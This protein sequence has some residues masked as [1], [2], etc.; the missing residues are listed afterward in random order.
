MINSTNTKEDV[1]EWIKKQRAN[2]FSID[3]IKEALA[4]RG[5]K[6]EKI[7]KIFSDLTSE[8]GKREQLKKEAVQIEKK[9]KDKRR[10]SFGYKFIENK[11][12]A[13][14]LFLGVLFIILIFFISLESNENEQK[15]LD[16]I[17]KDMSTE[18][19]KKAQEETSKNS[20]ILLEE[21][22]L[23]FDVNECLMYAAGDIS[24]LEKAQEEEV[25]QLFDTSFSR[26]EYSQKRIANYYMFNAIMENNVASCNKI[27]E[28]QSYALNVLCRAIVLNDP[29]IC[30]EATESNIKEFII[31]LGYI[32]FN[33][34]CAAYADKKL[35][36][37]RLIVSDVDKEI[38][39]DCEQEIHLISA[40]TDK[41]IEKC[42]VI[43]DHGLR[44]KCLS[45]ISGNTEHC[46]NYASEMCSDIMNNF[47]ANQY[48]TIIKSEA[49]KICNLIGNSEIKENCIAN[50]G[51]HRNLILI[52]NAF[53]ADSFIEC[54]NIEDDDARISC[55]SI[56]QSDVDM[57]LKSGDY[58]FDCIV[59]LIEFLDQPELCNEL[60]DEEII[61]CQEYVKELVVVQT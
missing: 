25:T 23:Y 24:Y 26:Q 8:A 14:I 9:R 36:S 2:G 53:A 12:I 18:D 55:L 13:A 39:T 15:A 3:N 37:C 29:L 27:D 54:K 34:L 11:K 51:K 46:S 42:N 6:E 44:F 21:C 33:S 49:L 45:L 22:K 19:I 48:I 28:P 38:I 1:K 4:K 57:C 20:K 59:N 47:I 16:Q 56:L 50:V 52:A 41:N 7:A 35:S 61:R 5:Y 60:S 43:E 31:G 17:L 30:K 40:L 32:G 10:I 58:K